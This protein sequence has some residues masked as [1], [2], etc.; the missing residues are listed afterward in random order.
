MSDFLRNRQAVT[1]PTGMLALLEITAP[2][3]SGPAYLAA[4]NRDWVSN[5]RTY[6]GVGFGFKMPD[7]LPDQSPRLRLSLTNVGRGW[8][9]ELERLGPNEAVKAVFKLTDKGNPDL[10]ERQWP[11]RLTNIRISGGYMTA[12]GGYDAMDRQQGV[13]LWSTPFTTPGLF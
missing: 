1:D 5:G 11:T 2:S 9:E 8:S 10:I 12:E 7:D 6:V 13:L 3:F 4:D